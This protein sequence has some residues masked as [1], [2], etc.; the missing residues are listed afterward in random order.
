MQTTLSQALHTPRLIV[1]M[2]EE[3]DLPELFQ[4]FSDAAVTR[5]LPYITWEDTLAAHSWYQRVKEMAAQAAA[6]Q[7]VIVDKASNKVIGSCL[8]FRFDAD[9][10]RAELGYALAQSHWGGGYMGEA[11]RALL[12]HAFGEMGINR[13]EAEVDPR[14]PA[15]AQLLKKL[16]FVQEG[17]LRQRWKFKG[18]IKDTWMFGLLRDEW[19]AANL[20][21]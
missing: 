6:M 8:L 16:G 14:N 10:E 9:S 17:L 2:I 3:D 7:C 21:G 18:E 12:N 11:I 13:I 15:S 1:R 5:F 4:V 20:P 19:Q